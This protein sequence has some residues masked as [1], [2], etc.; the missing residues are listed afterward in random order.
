[1]PRFCAVFNCSNPD[2]YHLCSIVKTNFREGLKLLKVRREKWLAEFFSKNLI[3]IKLQWTRTRIKIMLSVS[4]SL[5]F[6][7]KV[8]INRFERQMHILS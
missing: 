1:M 3:E 8:H 7:H 2:E 5:F 6:S 4:P